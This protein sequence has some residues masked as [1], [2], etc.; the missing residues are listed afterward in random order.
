[1][2]CLE[3][4]KAVFLQETAFIGIRPP[5]LYTILLFIDFKLLTSRAK[6]RINIGVFPKD[7]LRNRRM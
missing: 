7:V 1:M 2:L 6:D 5:E 3:T 4:Q